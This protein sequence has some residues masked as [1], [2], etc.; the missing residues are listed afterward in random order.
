MVLVRGSVMAQFLIHNSMTLPYT[1]LLW[2]QF[3]EIKHPFEVRQNYNDQRHGNLDQNAPS[4]V[5]HKR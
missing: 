3:N 4:T 2:Q 5:M 1:T